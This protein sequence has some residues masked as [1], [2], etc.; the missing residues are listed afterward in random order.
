MVLPVILSGGSGTRL[1][2]YSRSLFPKQFLPLVSDKTM[3]QETVNR[4]L[5]FDIAVEQPLVICNESHRFMVAEQLRAMDITPTDIILEPCGRNTAPAI[6]LAALS[7][8]EAVL[9]V[10]P[11]DHVIKNTEAFA[12]S[13]SQAT[14]QAQAGKLV[15]FGIVPTAA[16]TGY[17]YVKSGDSVGGTV[18]EV[19][20]FVEKPDKATAESYIASGNYLW[21]SGIFMFKS[22][23]YLEELE[24]F[25][26]EMLAACRK[27]MVS[28]TR[29]FD[30]TRID[31]EAFKACP[32]DSIDY[33]VME[34]TADAVVV[35][36]D[37][38]W[39]DVGSWSA[40]WEVSS[41]DDC[42]NVVKK[43][44]GDVIS[45]DTHNSYIQAEHKLVATIGLDNVVVVE[46]D[47]AILVAHKDRVQDVKT[48]VSQLKQA[49]RSEVSL[50]RKVY[51][52]WGYYDSID[53]GNRFQVKRIV[54]RPG[55]QLS[56]Q[57]HHHR[58][59]HWIVVE[60]TAEVRCGDNTMILSENQS[61]YIPL[62]EIHQLSNPGK[63]PLEIIEV[64]S[65]S[66]LGEDDIVRLKDVYGRK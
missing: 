46:T 3:L 53:G 16:E 23:R 29:D 51:R 40:L 32:E 9:L 58:A 12:Q 44:E 36:L 57:K 14:L 1:W 6:A 21:N 27:A 24:K 56:L 52:P 10:L 35:P 43:G 25:N 55:A 45:L 5:F 8:P 38:S 33:A 65:G 7:Q 37:A 66:Y 60:G 59:E 54:V 34:K 62:G 2:P 47:D 20:Q 42:G 18:C 19:E 64:Q 22:S 11:A 30:F 13:V 4:F 31:A 61:T 39:S 15:T 26:P 41:S 48:V 63:L 17:G 28:T 49:G 50:H